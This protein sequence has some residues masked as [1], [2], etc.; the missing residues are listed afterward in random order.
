VKFDCESYSS[1]LLGDAHLH[2]RAQEAQEVQAVREML[3]A[4]PFLG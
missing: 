1:A 4:M 3:E 2:H